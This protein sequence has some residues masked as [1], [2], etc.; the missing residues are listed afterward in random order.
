VTADCALKT[1]STSFMASATSSL[2]ASHLD[3]EVSTS[4]ETKVVVPVGSERE[5]AISAEPTGTGPQ[6]AG[7]R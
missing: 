2:P 7:A 3:A 6:K 5:W 4:A 1:A